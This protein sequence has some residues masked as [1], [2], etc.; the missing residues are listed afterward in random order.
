MLLEI[1]IAS[2]E[3]AVAA[4]AGG[5]RLELNSALA[6]G[7]LTPSLGLLQEVRQAVRLP[8]IAMLRPRCGG[9]CYSAGEFAV[10]QRDADLLLEHGADGLAFGILKE[11]GEIDE[12]RCAQIIRQARGREIVF[13]RAFDVT[14]DAVFALE[15]LIDL[16]VKRVM[17]SGQASNAVQGADNIAHYLQ[18]ARGRIEI[19]PAGGINPATLGGILARIPCDQVHASLRTVK[20]D[21]FA[22]ARAAGQFRAQRQLAVMAYTG[23]D[24]QAVAEMRQL[25]LDSMNGA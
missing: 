12:G 24:A 2:L 20:T 17:T 18:H 16:G 10:M 8:I 7:G 25:L 5:D 23:T 9:F 19:L 11:T 14:P 22:R 21:R 13:H 4:Q 15:E 6:L 3:D 1:C